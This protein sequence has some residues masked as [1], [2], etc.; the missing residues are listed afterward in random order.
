MGLLTATVTRMPLLCARRGS[1]R[2]AS[3]GGR[4]IGAGAYSEVVPLVDW[5]RRQVI[6]VL[7]LLCVIGLIALAWLLVT[8]PH[9]PGILTPVGAVW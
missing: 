9:A 3:T 5:L 4:T 2:V 6:A 1:P 8:S 7:I